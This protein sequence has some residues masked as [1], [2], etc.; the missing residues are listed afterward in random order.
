MKK[1]LSSFLL[2][3][4]FI[5]SAFATPDLQIVN[6]WYDFSTEYLMYSVT[7]TGTALLPSETVIVEIGQRKGRIWNYKRVNLNM[8]APDQDFRTGGVTTL[9]W[10][11]LPRTWSYI[12]KIC[13]DPDNDIKESSEK[14]CVQDTIS[15]V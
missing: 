12:F 8:M 15:T 14:N 1:I 5:P 4:A 10:I 13:I 11:K 3:L 9:A 2:S 7:N 6:M